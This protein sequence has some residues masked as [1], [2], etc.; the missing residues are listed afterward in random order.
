MKIAVS[1]NGRDVDSPINPRFGRSSGF[2][3]WDSETRKADYLDNSENL[4]LSQGAGIKTA[5]MIADAG[6]SVLITGQMGPKAAQ[7]LKH[8]KV[9]IYYC[10]SGTVKEAIEACQ[11]NQLEELTGEKIASGPGKMGGRGQGG[12]GGMGKGK[13]R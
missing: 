7:A 5:R 11:G 10:P 3:L 8:S 12:G 6:A 2:V 13:G 1:A 4:A 9:R